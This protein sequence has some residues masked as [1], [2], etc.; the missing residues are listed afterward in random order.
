MSCGKLQIP[1]DVPSSSLSL[2][3]LV[4]HVKLT[5]FLLD[6]RFLHIWSCYFGWLN[7]VK[8]SYWNTIYPSWKC[9]EIAFIFWKYSEPR[10]RKDNDHIEQNLVF[11]EGSKNTNFALFRFFAVLCLLT[12]LM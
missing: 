3:D 9:C 6:V 1:N 8:S 10:I 12:H 11:N 5:S 2:P 4:K 7:S